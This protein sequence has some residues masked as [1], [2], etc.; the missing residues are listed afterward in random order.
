M[1]AVFI[2]G[3]VAWLIPGHMRKRRFALP[4]RSAQIW[5][6]VTQVLAIAIMWGAGVYIKLLR[7]DYI[8]VA[9]ATTVALALMGFQLFT[10]QNGNLRA[11]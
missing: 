8:G 1:L 11:T 5:L 6:S 10:D 3:S 7:R 2:L 4:S 9:V